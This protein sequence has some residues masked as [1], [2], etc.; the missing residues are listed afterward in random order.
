MALPEIRL[1]DTSIILAEEL[2]FS[3]AGL[4]LHVD[5]S[6]VSKRIDE[7]EGQLG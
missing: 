2:H 4:R 3:R 5:Q 6:T 7:L 1:L